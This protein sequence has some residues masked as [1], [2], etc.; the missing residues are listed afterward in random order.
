MLDALRRGAR[1]RRRR[2]HRP[3][4][5]STCTHAP[6]RVRARAR[7]SATG[8]NDAG[9][10]VAGLHAD[11]RRAVD[12]AAARRRAC[13]PAR[14]PARATTRLRPSPSMPSALS[15]REVRL[16]ADDDRDRRR[17][18]QAVGLDVPAG[19]LEHRVARRGE[20]REVRHVAPVTNAP[21]GSGGQ[22][23]HVEQPLE[24]DLLEVRRA[25]RRR[26][27]PGVLVPRAGQPVRR[28]RRRQR[29]ADHEAEEAR[30]G[31]R[32]RRR[33]IRSRRAPRARAAASRDSSCSGTSSAEQAANGVGLGRYAA[34]GQAREIRGGAACGIL[35][36][37]FHG[38]RPGSRLIRLR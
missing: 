31:H 15:T 5:P 21:R 27:E 37:R 26:I 38:G 17:A 8:S 34:L 33:A 13:G 9:V 4:A 23:E 25:G 11:D 10:H 3:N 24:R 6:A 35:E 19:A 28:E 12:R 2:A 14:P 16:V 20:R 7:S 29:A 1:A 22:A 18:E 30:A 36:Q 32:H